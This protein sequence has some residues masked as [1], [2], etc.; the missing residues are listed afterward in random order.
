MPTHDSEHEVRYNKESR[1]FVAVSRDGQLLPEVHEV[2]AL[3]A[4]HDLALATGHVTPEEALAILKAARAAGVKRLIV[5]HPMFQPQYTWMS[6]D[7]MREAADLGAFLEVTGNSVVRD[8]EAAT[9]VLGAIRAIGAKHFFVA[10]DS[11]LVGTPNVTDTLALVAKAFRKAGISDRD[12]TAMFKDNPAFLVNL[13][14][15]PNRR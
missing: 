14:A 3:V 15:L 1:P 13:P 10:T 9:R 7:Q 11:G 12:L 5:T 4:Q 8:P 6:M 2:V